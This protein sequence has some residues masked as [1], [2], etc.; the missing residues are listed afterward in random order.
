M[1]DPYGRAIKGLRVSL[2][3]RCNLNCIY[4]HHEGEG[5]NGGEM[6][7]AEVLRIVKVARSLGVRRVKYT[8]GEPLLRSDIIEIIRGTVSMNLEDVAITTNG[9]LLKLY[10]PDLIDAGMH[11]LNVSL[12]SI[13]PEVYHSLTGGFLK[14]VIEGIREAQRLGMEIKVN[15]VIMKGVNEGEIDQLL[16]YAR[17]IH[18]GLQIIELENLNLGKP[19][20]EKYHKDLSDIE[21]RLARSADN[22][23]EREDVN[24][25]RRYTIN[26]LQVEVVRPVNNPHFCMR[27]SRLRV[28]SDGRL[29]PCLMRSD[30]LISTLDLIRRGC[31]DA[32]L[33]ELF[34][35]ALTLRS[36]YYLLPS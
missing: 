27:C 20:F 31:S 26:G 36:P 14:E 4:C 11:R 8:G 34:L 17:S 1:I 2:T 35:K 7:T 32:E 3:Q 9:S 23:T 10:A 12:P 24:Q 5:G 13:R 33:K 28:T 22:V 18:G 16:E 19:F 29:K 30:N 15:V 6:T 21:K 25:R